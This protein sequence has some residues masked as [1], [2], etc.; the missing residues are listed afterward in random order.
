MPKTDVITPLPKVDLFAAETW[1]PKALEKKLDQALKSPVDVYASGTFRPVYEGK[2]Q[3]RYEKTLGSLPIEAYDP[4]GFLATLGLVDS[5]TGGRCNAELLKAFKLNKDYHPDPRYL[6]LPKWLAPG[7]QKVLLSLN[8]ISPKLVSAIDH[9]ATRIVVEKME[10]VDDED[11]FP[12]GRMED[13][14]LGVRS[15]LDVRDRY[16]GL[17]QAASPQRAWGKAV[18]RGSPT[19]ERGE[20]FGTYDVALCLGFTEEQA[21]R[22]AESC[23]DV[24]TNETHYNDPREPW[25]QRIS[26]AGSGGHK[27][28]FH[29][30]FN[31][32]KPGEEDTRITAAKIHLDRAVEVAGQGYFNAAEREL[33]IGMHSL[34]DIFAHAQITPLN[35]SLLGEFPDFVRYNPIGMYEAAVATEGYLKQFVKRLGMQKQADHPHA[36]VRDVVGGNAAPE[37]KHAVAAAIGRYPDGL[38]QALR[39]NGVQIYVGAAGT[40]LTDL[41]FGVDLDGD[42]AVTP[43]TWVDVNQDGVQQA[44]EVE[45]TAP[46]GR[47]WNEQTAAYNHDTR[48]IFISADAASDPTELD[49]I[50][51]HEIR[52]AIDLTFRD[53]PQLGVKWTAYVYRLLDDARRKG[54]GD[55]DDVDPYE[56]FAA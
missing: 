8:K 17:V 35:H 3:T 9:L 24:D 30:H 43:G 28:D 55:F 51:K 27:G 15:T 32:S 45:D 48:T 47:S 39:D 36:A 22:I 20:D 52:H 16:F 21:L 50:L 33:G 40:K 6:P 11:P 7:V 49:R 41:G 56:L 10:S 23:D 31:R 29:W 46:D 1:Q 54:V 34:Q 12:Y 53:D 2:D 14:D 38:M 42:G 4:N 44:F 26:K 18:H 19:P 25:K 5:V 13:I 37:A